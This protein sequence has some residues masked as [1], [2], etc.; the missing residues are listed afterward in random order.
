MELHE[1]LICI[2]ISKYR[3]P[4]HKNAKRIYCSN[5][6]LSS[7]RGYST[8]KVELCPLIDFTGVISHWVYFP[9]LAKG[10]RWDWSSRYIEQNR[11]SY[12]FC[13][14]STNRGHLAV[15]PLSCGSKVIHVGQV[16]AEKTV[17]AVFLYVFR[18]AFTASL[19]QKHPKQH[20]C[21]IVRAIKFHGIFGEIFV[22]CKRY[23]IDFFLGWIVVC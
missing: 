22:N 8:Y 6:T 4:Y 5:L 11:F 7:T 15:V 12:V 19:F 2:S 1:S 21:R 18:I 17:K 20:L 10:G 16:D 23:F 9:R 13:M 3:I 14:Q